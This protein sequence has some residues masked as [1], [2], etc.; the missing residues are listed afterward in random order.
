MIEKRFEQIK[1][2]HEIASVFLKDEGRIEALFTVY[3]L[4]LLLQSLIEHEL[5]LAMDREGIED[6]PLYPK[7]RPCARPTIEQVLRLFGLVE[8]HRLLR[9]GRAIQVFEA[10]LTDFPRQ[11]LSLLGMSE[12]AFRSKK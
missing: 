11:V 5:R 3:F 12:Q 8:R 7:L 10:T 9:E 2:V 4:T 6:L 1:T